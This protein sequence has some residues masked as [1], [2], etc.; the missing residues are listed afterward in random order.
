[1]IHTVFTAFHAYTNCILM[2]MVDSMPFHIGRI[3]C[4]FCLNMNLKLSFVNE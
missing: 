2:A 1:M 4:K 3:Q